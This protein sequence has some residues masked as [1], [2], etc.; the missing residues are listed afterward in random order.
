MS[1]GFFQDSIDLPLFAERRGKEV[2]RQLRET[3]ACAWVR[4]QA[5]AVHIVICFSASV[6]LNI[7]EADFPACGGGSPLRAVEQRPSSG[8]ST[9]PALFVCE[10]RLPEWRIKKPA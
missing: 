1:Q 7:S 6:F 2:V 4:F 5:S 8:P 3:I 9:I 10:Q